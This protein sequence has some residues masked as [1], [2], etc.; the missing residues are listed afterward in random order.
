MFACILAPVQSLLS[1]VVCV[2]VLGGE[3]LPDLMDGGAGGCPA[4]PIEATGFLINL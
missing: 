1:V 2:V 3:F 4:P